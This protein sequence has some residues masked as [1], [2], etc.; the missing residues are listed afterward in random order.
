MNLFR[1]SLVAAGFALVG[2]A[3]A[4]AQDALTA[5]CKDG[6]SWSGD[7]RSGACRGHK[8][9][10]AFGT[11]PMAATQT[12]APAQTAPVPGQPTGAPAV[13]PT[14]M[15]APATASG[16]VATRAQAPGGGAGQVW[17][18]TKT[19]V[20][21]C[22]GDRYYGKTKAGAYMTETAAKAA[23]DHGERG[24]TCS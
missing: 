2:A 8:G 20:Y 1:I 9:V 22:P 3:G 24:K 14:A 5:T 19:K 11:Q 7:H 6:T 23:G 17:V 13:P 15:A 4:H 21:H 16:S 10:Q 18:N 12:A